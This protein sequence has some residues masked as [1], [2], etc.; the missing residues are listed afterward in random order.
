MLGAFKARVAPFNVNYR[1]VAEELRYLLLDSNAAAVVVHSQFAPD[2]RRGAARPPEPARH[3]PGA[4][5]SRGNDLLPGAVWYED[6]LAAASADRPAVRVEPRRPLHPLHRRHH[7]HAQGRAVAQRRRQR[8]VLRRQRAPTRSTAC[9]AEADRWPEGAARSPVHA[10]R[11][12]LDELPHVEHRRH[13]LRAER[14]RAPRPGR[15]LGPHRARAVELPAHRR[16]RVR[17]PAARRARQRQLRPVQPHR[18][19]VRWRTA[20]RQSEGGVPAPPADADDRR[21][22]RLVGGRRAALARVGRQRRHHRH[23]PH[24]PR[25]PRAQRRPHPRARRPATRRSAGWPRAAA[26]RSATWATRRRRRAP[27]RSSAAPATPSPATAPGC[28]PTASSS[29]TAATR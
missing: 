24:Q 4:P 7:G 15:H 9:V 10:R 3:P 29:S 21:R 5:T 8:R 17:P 28:A 18:A 23:V 25:Q 11:R 26:S 13:R 14:P 19:P 6:A 12:A 27:T 16:R 1:Y 22:A 20:E 2:A